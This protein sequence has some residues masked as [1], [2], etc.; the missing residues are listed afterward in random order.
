MN[1]ITKQ[2]QSATNGLQ[3]FLITEFLWQRNLIEATAWSGSTPQVL[4]GLLILALL[5]PSPCYGRR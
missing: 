5:T 1:I 2:A 4:A 3:G